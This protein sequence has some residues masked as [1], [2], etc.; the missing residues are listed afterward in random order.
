MANAFSTIIKSEYP[1]AASISGVAT[2]GIAQGAL[3]AE[4]MRLPMTYVR[5]SAKGHGRQNQVEGVVKQG[6]ET[7]VIEDLIST[8]GSSLKAVEALRETGAKVSGLV[9]IF[10]YGFK[11]IT[12]AFKIAYVPFKTLTN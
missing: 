2:G 9:A 7:V 6:E 8:G 10:N 4:Q 1:N 11:K 5:S 12:E 3:V